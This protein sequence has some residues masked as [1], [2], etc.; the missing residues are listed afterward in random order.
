MQLRWIAIGMACSCALLT[1]VDDLRGPGNDAGEAG[2]SAPKFVQQNANDFGATASASLAFTSP[3]KAHDTIVV[4]VRIDS[5]SSFGTVVVTDT[6]GDSFH[7]DVG[8]VDTGIRHY[9][10]S[11]NDVAGGSPDVKATVAGPP[12]VGLMT[13]YL[14]EYSGISAFATGIGVTGSTA[15]VSSGPR[16]VASP[17]SLVV[18]FLADDSTHVT[19]DLAFNVRSTV[20]GVAVEDEIAPT[21]GTYAATGTTDAGTPWAALMAIYSP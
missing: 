13:I 18:G 20:K 2:A 4:C 10:F 21:I 8:P 14:L 15:D 7:I 1:N 17:S 11:A 19:A 16:Q 12:P 3:V 6:A 5:S 9:I